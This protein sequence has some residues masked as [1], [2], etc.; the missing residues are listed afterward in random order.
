MA[1]TTTEHTITIESADPNGVVRLERLA[2]GA[3]TPGDLLDITGAAVRAHATAAGVLPG[4][5]VALENQTPDT[6][7][8][9][10][11]A[12]IDID[13]AS[14]DTVYYAQGN[15]G[16][17]F[18]M[19]LSAGEAATDGVTQLQSDGAGALAA[20]TVGATTLADSI[21]GVADETVDN[22]G[23]GAAVRLRVRIT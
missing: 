14:G 8:Y 11:T 4:K 17:V 15:P 9:P 22:S 18:L 13:Y 21:V 16:D 7:T 23:G 19:W 1:R 10:T 5:L 12:A 6:H 2:S 20:V 3:V